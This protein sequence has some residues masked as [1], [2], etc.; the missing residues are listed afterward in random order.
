MNNFII[1]KEHEGKVIYAEPMGVAAFYYSKVVKFQVI[2]V[3]RKYVDLQAEGSNR[4]ETVCPV[5]GRTHESIK[6]GATSGGFSFYES[7]DDI[8]QTREADNKLKEITQVFRNLPVKHLSF[9]QITRI[10]SILFDE[11]VQ[12]KN[13]D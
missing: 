9:S 12:T 8:K 4:I 11:D 1:T 3:K 10:H 5:T 7:M 2:K 13:G 6:R